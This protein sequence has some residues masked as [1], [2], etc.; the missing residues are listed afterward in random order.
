MGRVGGEKVLSGTVIFN[1]WGEDWGLGNYSM[2]LWDFL[3]ISYYLKIVRCSFVRQVVRW[4]GYTSL[5]LI[6][7]LRFTCGERKIRSTTKKFENVMNM[8]VSQH[9]FH[10]E[11]FGNSCRKTS[12]T[13]SANVNILFY[14]S[15][16]FCPK[17]FLVDCGLG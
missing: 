10:N 13:L 5:L 7:T 1:S 12:K 15:F 2:E 4:I 8:I 11:F 6:I 9:A 14:L 3:D 17:S 16:K